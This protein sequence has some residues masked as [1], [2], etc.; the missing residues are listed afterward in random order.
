MPYLLHREGCHLPLH[1]LNPSCIIVVYGHSSSHIWGGGAT[2]SDVTGSHRTGS[3]VTEV[4]SAHAY[5]KYGRKVSWIVKWF[6]KYGRKISWI[7]ERFGKY[8]RRVSWIVKRYV[9][10]GRK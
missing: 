10:Y 9:K 6:G 1:E 8:G 5:G 3:D 7:V 2:G 4:C